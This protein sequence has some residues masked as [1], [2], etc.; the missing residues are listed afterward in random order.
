MK[1][2][3]SKLCNERA[4]VSGP[5]G[6][7]LGQVG[8]RVRAQL[9]RKRAVHATHCVIGEITGLALLVRA[10]VEPVLVKGTHRATSRRGEARRH[11]NTR[12]L[13]AYE[14]G[15]GIALLGTKMT[16]VE[17]RKT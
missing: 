17:R 13:Y 9:R 15:T 11:L 4:P 2:A 1:Y 14:H 16:T 3:T 12:T 5:L 7:L 6:E 10:W 8:A